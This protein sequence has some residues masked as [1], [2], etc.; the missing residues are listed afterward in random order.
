MT[1]APNKPVLWLAADAAAA[2][3]GKAIGDDWAATGISIDSR[4]VAPGDLFV[5]IKGPNFDGHDFVDAALAAGA[6]AAVVSQGAQARSGRGPLL[7]VEDTLTALQDLGRVARLRARAKV[8][9]VTGSVGKTGTKEALR[10][11]LSA[12]ASTFATTGSLNNHWGVPLSLSRMP[13]DA[14]FGIFELGMNHAGEIGPLSRQVMP[15]VGI[16]TTIQPAHIENLGTIEAIADAKA[17]LFEGMSPNG[18]AILN[19]DDAQFPRLIAAAR[20]RGIGRILTF[21]AHDEADARLIDCALHATSSMATA[22]IRG[23]ILNYCV[24]VPGRHQVMNSLAVLLAVSAVGGDLE[25]AVTALAQISPIKGRGARLRV[26]LDHGVF[27]I[28]D[29]SYNASPAAMEA[30]F[31]VLAKTDPGA[32]GR[33]IAVLGD[34]LELGV[35]APRFHAGLAEPLIACGVDLV[36]CCGPRMKH[37]FDRLP[38]DLKGHHA[39]DSAALAPVVAAA[40]RAGDVIMVKGSLGSRMAAV[41]DALCALDHGEATRPA[42][43]AATKT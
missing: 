9:A 11:C 31:A 34:M 37:L 21:G 27:V 33:R 5:A 17:E 23:E 14:A 8:I 26:T 20:T 42:V 15:D 29:E 38:D 43:K 3:N 2:T 41:I 25:T 24:S 35:T 22:S 10:A 36:F 39:S 28:I 12:C 1:G 19:R 30:A 13:E 7:V 4:S 40:A 16:I 32:G 6:S 18:T